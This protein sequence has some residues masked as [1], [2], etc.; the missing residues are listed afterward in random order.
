[1]NFDDFDPKIS[2]DSDEDDIL[3]DFYKPALERTVRYQRLAGYFSSTVFVLVLKEIIDFIKKGGRIQL[4]TSIN[5]SQQ[6]IDTIELSVEN[7]E[8]ILSQNLLEKLQSSDE[9]VKKS[10]AIFGYMLTNIIDGSPQLEMKI[11]IPQNILSEDD[12]NSIYHQKVGI[13][14]DDKEHVITFSGSVNETGKAFTDNIEDFKVFQ[15]EKDAT[16]REA[17]DSDQK[18]F[19]KFW[20]NMAQRT[21]IYELPVAVKEQFLKAR[22]KSNKEFQEDILAVESLL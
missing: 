20:K 17:V 4:V 2:W 14:K 7:R 22:S 10:V 19:D 5:L 3:N 9:V 1:M 12:P 21:S 15:S 6:D 18:K 16:H 11:A 8:K 13:M